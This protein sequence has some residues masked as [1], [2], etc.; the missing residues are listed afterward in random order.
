MMSQWRDGLKF[1]LQEAG[2]QLAAAELGDLPP[3]KMMVMFGPRP[4]LSQPQAVARYVADQLGKLGLEVELETTRDS[5]DYFRRVTR[6][7]YDLALTGWIADT[8]DPID[9]LESC[10]AARA[11]PSPGEISFHAN[12]DHP[13]EG[14]DLDF[15]PHTARSAELRYGLTNSFGFGGTNGALVMAAP[16]L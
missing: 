4:Y 9:F 8:L 12:L 13:G 3:L 16:G 2:S 1:D 5:E 7:D 6:G 14:C 10:L 11:I 15:V